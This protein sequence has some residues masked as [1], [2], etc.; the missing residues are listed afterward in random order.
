LLVFGAF[1]PELYSVAPVLAM[2]QMVA[3]L[4]LKKGDSLTPVERL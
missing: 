2:A 1:L 4:S 3:A